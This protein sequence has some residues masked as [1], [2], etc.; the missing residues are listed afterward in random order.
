[1][2]H[3]RIRIL[4]CALACCS[5]WLTGCGDTRPAVLH[6]ENLPILEIYD[7]DG[8]R[9]EGYAGYSD[10]FVANTLK[11]CEAFLDEAEKH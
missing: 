5:G 11:A 7:R 3:L 4:L 9:L 1:M 6:D 8:R 2:K 10:G